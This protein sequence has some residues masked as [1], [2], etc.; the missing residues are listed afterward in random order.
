MCTMTCSPS[1]WGRFLLL[2]TSSLIP[3]WCSMGRSPWEPGPIHGRL[4]EYTF[5]TSVYPEYW[6]LL[7]PETLNPTL[8]IATWWILLDYVFVPSKLVCLF[9]SLRKM[10]KLSEVLNYIPRKANPTSNMWFYMSKNYQ[11]KWCLVRIYS[12]TI[13]VGESISDVSARVCPRYVPCNHQ[14]PFEHQR[15]VFQSLLNHPGFA[16]ILRTHEEV[17]SVFQQRN[18]LADVEESEPCRQS[19]I[20]LGNQWKDVD[21]DHIQSSI[22]RFNMIQY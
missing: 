1:G 7:K 16:G 22:T 8:Q 19:A 13:A 18:W 10:L 6:R 11:T 3:A 2:F 15:S 4:L 12:T 9:V 14:Y 17:D 5:Y 20:R 21:P